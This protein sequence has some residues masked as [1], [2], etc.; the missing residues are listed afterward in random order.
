M[1][2][3]MKADVRCQCDPRH[4]DCL[5]NRLANGDLKD[6]SEVQ[7]QTACSLCGQSPSGLE[8]F[9]ND[10]GKQLA[11]DH[12]DK[13]LEAIDANLRQLIDRPVNVS[14][15][16]DG[17]DAEGSLSQVGD[18]RLLREIGRGGMGVV[19]EAEQVSLGRRVA[20]KVLPQTLFPDDTAAARFERE[21][22]AAAKLHHTNI[23]P[24]F[25]SGS[26]QGVNFYAMQLIEGH[27]LDA[28]RDE[29]RKSQSQAKI[30]TQN[31]AETIKESAIESASPPPDRLDKGKLEEISLPDGARNN[32]FQFVADIGSQVAS[33]LQ[34]AHDRDVVHRDV[35]PSNLILDEA[36]VVWLADFGLAKQG[37]DGLT[38]T[39][40]AP[41]TLR[42]M[43]PERFQGKA[44]PV[45]DVYS[46]GASLYEMLTLEPAFSAD[47]PLELI[48]KIKTSRPK[49]PKAS[50]TSVPLDLQT[51]VL[52]AM[53]KDPQRRYATAAEM[54]DDLNRFR[55]HQPIL[56]RKVGAAERLLLWAKNNKLVAGL[57][58]SL[59]VGLV[60][61]AVASTA[62]AMA[63]RN[64]AEQAEKRSSELEQVA[65]FQ[66]SQLSE[67][68]VEKMG[69]DM[70]NGLLEEAR[71]A[72]G[73]SKLNGEDTKK[74]IEELNQRLAGTNFTNIAL[75]TLETNIFDRAKVAIDADFDDQPIVQAKLL[76]TVGESMRELGLWEVAQEP[77]QQAVEIFRAKLGDEHPDT[78]NSIGILGK[79]LQSL[80]KLSE[81]EPL[82]QQ[83]LSGRRRLLGDEHP[84][85]LNAM[86]DLGTLRLDQGNLTEAENYLTQAVS[87]MRRELGD[88]HPNTLNH[89]NTL[90]AI[91]FALGK[92]S[93]SET[94]RQ[95]V[96]STRRRVLGDDHPDTLVSINNEG[97]ALNREGKRTEAEPLLREA[98]VG[99][100]RVLGDEHP[101]TLKVIR[102]LGDSL[103]E[104][105]KFTEAEPLLREA[106]SSNRR[107][108]GNEHPDTVVSIIL[109]A[110]GLYEGGK[111]DEA[112]TLRKE[113]LA[114]RRRVLG[115]ED[116]DTLVSMN[117]LGSILFVRK[118]LAEAEAVFDEALS[119]RRRVLGNEHPDTLYSVH[120]LARA[121]FDQRKLG[122]AEPLFREAL[123]GRRKVLGDEHLE[124]LASI[125][126][127]AKLLFQQRN[128]AE[129]QALYEEELSTKRRVLSDEAPETLTSMVNLGTL[130]Y[131]GG[132]RAE[133]EKVFS[134]SL[135]GR[136]R[137]LGDEHPDTFFSLNML[138]MVVEVRGKLAEAATLYQEAL[139]IRRRTL[140]DENPDTLKAMAIYAA[141]LLKQERFADA[142]PILRECFE[143]RKK[144]LEENDWRLASNQSM[145]GQAIAGQQR[146]VEAEPLLVEGYEKM[147][148]PAGA[149]MRKTE[150]L[151]RLVDF[152]AAWHEAEPDQGYDAK[153]A[154]WRAKLGNNE[155]NRP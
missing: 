42:Y 51:I 29:V 103:R 150:A 59:L 91:F 77:T 31:T 54:A 33:A 118:K 104:Q 95:E 154:K 48:E 122:D 121:L 28:V 65:D 35:K 45:G 32:Y 116:P 83:V 2:L 97:N 143:G 37:D 152:Y 144:I 114:T 142:E 55:T 90:A 94:L 7:N 136:R 15:E 13:N 96:L 147:E 86:N 146:F 130:Q 41:G 135:A 128:L 5:L 106:L 62:G 52:K 87:G 27:P 49:S 109:L 71:I 46:L 79:L 25:D 129:S 60:V 111:L 98:L 23:V 4:A 30:A 153:V 127:L 8:S 10:I 70:R 9:A 67:I 107:V 137:V 93:E 1:E 117:S 21:A 133:A 85:T 108:L 105:G 61:V 26:D 36:G 92:H 140:G 16:S 75:D 68:D 64:V 56:A 110:K 3:D 148:P 40:Q 14:P 132:K 149:T 66:A 88:E 12:A 113:E 131:A 100:R 17:T 138:A 38:G 58:A 20:V 53:E 139:S 99:F 34:H 72:L 115:D 120:N 125:N 119:N 123:A 19:Y 43:S 141:T 101:T 11:V 63:Y 44:D 39:S 69:L 81:A 145:L 57:A 80:G 151:Q 126:I 102:N 112:E 78:L 74:R 73:R 124:T 22:S 76:L 134:E 18:Y 155:T 89:I 82:L 24:V 84:D 50:N 6:D 47:D